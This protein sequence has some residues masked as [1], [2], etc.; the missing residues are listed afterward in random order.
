MDKE[1]LQRMR[2][3][4]YRRGEYVVVGSGSEVEKLIK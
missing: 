4:E 1:V 3:E 2:K